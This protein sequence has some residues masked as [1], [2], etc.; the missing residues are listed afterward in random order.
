[1][2]R[3]KTDIKKI[4]LC[5]KPMKSSHFFPSGFHNQSDRFA[6]KTSQNGVDSNCEQGMTYKSKCIKTTHKCLLVPCSTRHFIIPPKVKLIRYTEHSILLYKVNSATVVQSCIQ[7]ADKLTMDFSLKMKI[8]CS[9]TLL[10]SAVCYLV[11]PQLY[12][13]SKYYTTKGI[14]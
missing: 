8:L 6:P 13:K 1:M 2:Q 12:F 10:S 5:I 4:L 14:L 7:R 3:E 11:S 9:Y